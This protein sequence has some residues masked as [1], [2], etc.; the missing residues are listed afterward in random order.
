MDKICTLCNGLESGAL[1]CRQCGIWMENMGIIED[2]LGPYSPYMD[3][4]SF[5]YNNRVYMSGDNMCIHLFYCPLCEGIR[6]LPITIKL[7]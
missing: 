5:V 6:Y 3:R 4:Y 1:Y 7:I 2:Y